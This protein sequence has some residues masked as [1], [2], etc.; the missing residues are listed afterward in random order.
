MRIF[1]SVVFCLSIMTS[2]LSADEKE[3][4]EAYTRMKFHALEGE[5]DLAL[6]FAVRLL[7]YLNPPEE[8]GLGRMARH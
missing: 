6:P 8:M 3:I 2:A 1:F 5:F 7:N 4:E